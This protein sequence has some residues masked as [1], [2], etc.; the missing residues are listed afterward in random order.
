MPG[1]R[2]LTLM[3]QNISRVFVCLLMAYFNYF[4]IIQTTNADWKLL[5]FFCFHLN[6]GMFKYAVKL[7]AVL[8]VLYK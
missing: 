3:F 7:L 5:R 2:S 8:A 6:I 4:K 1:G